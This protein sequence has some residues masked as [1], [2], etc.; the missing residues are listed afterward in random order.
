MPPCRWTRRANLFVADEAEAASARRDV[1]KLLARLPA[2]K[3][4]LVRAVK[5]DGHSIADEAARTGMSETS[6]KVTIHR[7]LKS[8]GEELGDSNADR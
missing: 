7:A 5:L 3:R 6:V 8:L 4:A 1:E 2:A